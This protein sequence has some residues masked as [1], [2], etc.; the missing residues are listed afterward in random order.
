MLLIM[1][2]MMMLYKISLHED[3]A[4]LAR[5]SPDGHI[6]APFEKGGAYCFAHVGRYMYVGRSVCRSV[7]MSVVRFVGIP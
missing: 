2:S 5:K 7:G 3:I 4:N 6:Y 1:S